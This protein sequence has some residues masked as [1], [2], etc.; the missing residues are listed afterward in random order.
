MCED[1]G[2]STMYE[3]NLKKYIFFNN[4]VVYYKLCTYVIIYIFNV[5]TIFFMKHNK[6]REV[7]VF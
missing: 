3:F 1:S 6:L 7:M 5:G 2:A 4:H